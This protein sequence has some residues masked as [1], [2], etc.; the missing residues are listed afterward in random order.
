MGVQVKQDEAN[1][2]SHRRF[3]FYL[4]CR[5]VRYRNVSVVLQAGRNA[6]RGGKDSEG[7]LVLS[8]SFSKSVEVN[9]ANR[10]LSRS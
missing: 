1:I 3:A 2:L 7:I 6:A 4:H 5:P 9:F 10:I 8:G